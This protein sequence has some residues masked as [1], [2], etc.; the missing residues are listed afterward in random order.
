LVGVFFLCIYLVSGSSDLKHNGDTDLRYQTTQAVVDYHRLWIEHPMWLDTRVATGIGGHLYAFYA[1]GQAILMVP[2][3]VAGKFLAHHLALPYDVTTLYTSRSL[4]LV[5]GAV[6]AV[7]FFLMAMSV[8]YSSRVSVVL[9]LIFGLAT[10]VWPDAQSALEQTQVNLLLLVAVFA[11]WNFVKGHLNDR[12]WLVAAGTAAGLAFFTRY[13]AVLYLPL[14]I[15]YPALT[16]WR[17]GQR[18]ATIRDASFYA[19]S[20]LPWVAGIAVW[21]YARFGSPFLTGLHEPTFGEP[22]WSGF[23]GLTISP[24]KGLI[25]YLPLLLILPWAIPS[26]YRR[27]RSLFFFL[28]ALVAA[29]VLF[30]SNVLY[31]HGDPAW[32]PRYLYVVVPYL[33][34]P[35]GEIFATWRRRSALLRAILVALIGVSFVL[36]VSAVSVTQWRFW[37]RLQVAEQGTSR[38]FRWGA[39]HY[40]YYWNLQDS[41]IRIQLDNVYQVL[42]LGLGEQR[43]RL[44]AKPADPYVTSNPAQEYPVN[45]LAFWWSD[46]RHP[47]LAERTR[48]LIALGLAFGAA[49]TL[50]LLVAQMLHGGRAATAGPLQDLELTAGETARR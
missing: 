35:L 23:L 34:L 49:A 16:R 24:G 48:V 7:V 40:H 11:V 9:T 44:S 5:L 17:M 41:P 25:W 37:Y 33:V 4:D 38:P 43:Y 1:P 15:L 2:F 27:S 14:I 50:A 32:G 36:Q 47:L 21:N 42:R 28:A 30:Y 13:D 8:G 10:V 12:R 6:L 20:A 3:Y 22:P 18:G 39:Q 26:F 19:L 31:W 46:V 45:T 29:T